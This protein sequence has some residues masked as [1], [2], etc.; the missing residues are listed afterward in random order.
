[1]K[2]ILIVLLFFAGTTSQ[3][4]A[5]NDADKIQN[6]LQE[7][8]REMQKL[9][10]EFEGL[11]GNSI[12]MTDSIVQKGVLPLAENFKKFEQLSTDSTDFNALIDMM[13]LQLNQ[14][15][16][17]DWGYLERLMK[18]FGEKMPSSGKK[19]TKRPKTDI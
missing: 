2:N 10:T 7:M 15:S 14:I 9:M 6:Q 18:D 17:E 1:M 3:L 4:N 19:D 5:Q 11:M 16:Q 13:Q 12:E 8:T